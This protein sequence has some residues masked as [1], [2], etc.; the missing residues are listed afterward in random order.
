MTDNRYRSDPLARW[1]A[2]IDAL[3]AVV[4]A[5]PDQP[6]IDTAEAMEI[7]RLIAMRLAAARRNT[8]PAAWTRRPGI[9][10]HLVPD[11]RATPAPTDRAEPAPRAPHPPAR[12]RLAWHE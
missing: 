10:P 2:A 9:V 1:H 7:Q 6:V 3:E 11:P 8:L 4:L 12:P 5:T